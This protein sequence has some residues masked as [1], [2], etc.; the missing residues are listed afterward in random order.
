GPYALET[1]FA[2]FLGAVKPLCR[3][4]WPVLQQVIILMRLP[5][6]AT[7]VFK[8]DHTGIVI[9]RHG[10]LLL[11]APGLPGRQAQR[12]WWLS[13]LCRHVEPGHSSN[14]RHVCG[15]QVNLQFTNDSCRIEVCNQR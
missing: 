2:G 5:V 15:E 1:R 7:G 10:A 8:A 12:G 6:A 11:R 13:T 3:C 4:L 14:R 9:L